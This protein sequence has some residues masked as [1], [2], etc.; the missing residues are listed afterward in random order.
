MNLNTVKRASKR[1]STSYVSSLNIQAYGAD[2]IYPQRML[3]LILNSPTGGVCVERYQQFIEGNGYN[4]EDFSEY[5]VN[6]AGETVDDIHRLISRDMALYHGFALHVNYNMACQIVELQYVPFQ[7]CRLEE[8]N[9]QGQVLFINVHPDWTGRKTRKGKRISVDINSVSKIHTFNPRK[10][11]VIAQIIE[12]GGIEHYKGQILWFSMDGKT[13]YPRPIYDKV[14]TNLST[15]E[16]LDNVKYRNA[17]NNF[18]LAGMLCRKKGASLGIDENGNPID[19]SPEDDREFARSLDAFQGDM[20]CCTIMDVTVQQD[21]DMPEFKA[22]EGNNFDSKFT[23][24][25]ESVTS[26]IYSAFGQEP[27]LC[28]RNGKLGFSGTVIAEAYEYYNSYVAPQR[29]ALSRA[30]RSIF[31]HWF[32]DANKSDDFLIQPLVY[33]NNSSNGTLSDSAGDSQVRPTDRK[34]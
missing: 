19:N 4:D 3:D 25:E 29:R 27:W 11:V 33:I 24:T 28:I 20:N 1:F 16:A 14:V 22:I 10:E 5:I 12:A 15:D 32:E 7:N 17:R 2:N 21:E 9:D 26:R 6:R 23:C 34:G 13:E 18:L 8:E 31:R 30:I